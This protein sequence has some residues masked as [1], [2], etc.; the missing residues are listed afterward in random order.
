MKYRVG[1]K[2]ILVVEDDVQLSEALERGL[3]AEG[4]EVAR[5][6]NGIDALIALAKGTFSLAVV[7]VMLPSMSGLEISRRIREGGSTMPVL[8]LTAR[9]AVDDRVNGL[10]A[11]AD[12]YLTKPFSF[13][14]LAARI[15]ALLR[16]ETS[17]SRSV[18]AGNVRLD[19]DSRK[20][21]VGERQLSLS[22]NEFLLLKALLS[23]VGTTLPRDEI[24]RSIWGTVENIDRNILEQYISAL[25]KKLAVRDSRV[26]IVTV[27]QVGYYAEVSS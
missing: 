7:D 2:S 17:E 5:V 24:L 18:E 15:R 21:W 1:V 11:G 19:S 8:L 4:Y 13:A 23:Q 20:A 16:R 14:E 12:D 6:G 22:P 26:S 27:R 25:R 9:D 10:D 3:L